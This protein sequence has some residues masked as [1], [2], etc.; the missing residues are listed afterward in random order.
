[1]KIGC[2]WLSILLI[3]DR[4]N[5]MDKIKIEDIQLILSK[6]ELEATQIANSK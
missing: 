5:K 3:L 6:E 4:M 1:M 2:M